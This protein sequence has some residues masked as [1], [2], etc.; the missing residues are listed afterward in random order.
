[1]V[2][3]VVVKVVAA[4]IAVAVA[5][6]LIL[7]GHVGLIGGSVLVESRTPA[8]RMFCCTIEDWKADQGGQEGR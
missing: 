1:M 3:V 4:A 7:L 8:V 6:V 2:L 5:V